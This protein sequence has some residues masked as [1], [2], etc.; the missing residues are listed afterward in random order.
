[1][2]EHETG[3]HFRLHFNTQTNR[4]S[5]DLAEGHVDLAAVGAVSYIRALE[6]GGAVPLVRGLNS[7]GRASYTSVIVVAPNGGIA[8]LD[9]LRGMRFAFGSEDSTQ[10]HLIPRI[11]LNEAGIALTDLASHEFTGSHQ[12]CANAVISGSADAC[13]MQ[14]TLGLL[15]VKQGRLRVLHQSSEYPS[16]SIAAAIGMPPDVRKKIIRALLAFDPTGRHAATLYNWH[17]TEMPNGFARAE[18][19]DYDN[20]RNSLEALGLMNSNLAQ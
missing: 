20:L 5:D 18:P 1:Y 3:H 2:L 16:S 13:G 11:V 10:G 7:E 6:D 12:S 17:R 8:A 14:D 15:L 9:D 19:G 4:L